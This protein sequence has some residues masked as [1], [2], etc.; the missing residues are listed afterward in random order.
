M[1]RFRSP[2]AFI[3]SF[4]KLRIVL[5]NDMRS[6]YSVTKILF[7]FLV[8]G[9]FS[10]DALGELPNPSIKVMSFN[11]RYGTANDGENVWKNRDRFVA[12]TIKNFDPDLLGGQEVLKFQADFLKQHLPDYGFHGVGRDNG[13]EKG[14]YV[15]IF[16]R[17]ER[18]DLIEAGHFWLSEN[19]EEPGSVSW[20]SSLTRMVSWVALDDLKDGKDTIIVFANTHFD[21]RGKEARHE[22][23]K[24]I[25][26]MRDQ[27]EEDLPVILTG[28]FNTTEDTNAYK[29]LTKA[30]S[31][32]HY[33]Y[34]DLIDSYRVIHPQRSD[35]E[36]SFSGFKRRTK[37]SRIDFVFHSKQFE[38]INAS[39]DYTQEAG[40]NPSDHYPVTA[41]LKIK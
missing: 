17:K 1:S 39:I 38:T 9:I 26:K 15:P 5:V 16:Y 35:F 41:I 14:E 24:L 31:N 40:R 10:S 13:Q 4:P 3:F 33:I 37:G 7:V 19:P 11:I 34:S 2:S 32:S 36:A 6:F 12:E 21:H 22:S 18:F 8:T 29:A 27:F 25:R 30:P 28:D 20:D 23:A